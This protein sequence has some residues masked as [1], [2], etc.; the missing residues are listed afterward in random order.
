MP[1]FRALL[2]VGQ[3]V[4]ADVSKRHPRMS[5]RQHGRGQVRSR[6]ARLD[7]LINRCRVLILA[8]LWI[9]KPCDVYGLEKRSRL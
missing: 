6:W 4:N 8:R 9:K 5:T 3:S 7:F 2:P 1:L